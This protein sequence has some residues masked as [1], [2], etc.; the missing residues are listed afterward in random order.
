MIQKTP[1]VDT[2]AWVIFTAYRAARFA[3]LM[4]DP[5]CSVATDSGANPAETPMAEPEDEP[6]GV[7]QLA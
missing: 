5:S 2:L 3:G 1:L 7:Y 6:P 4:A